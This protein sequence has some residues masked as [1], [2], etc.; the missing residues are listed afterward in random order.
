MNLKTV[1]PF[2]YTFPAANPKFTYHN[3]RTTLPRTF[4]YDQTL[5]L[6]RFHL[7]VYRK[8]S[9]AFLPLPDLPVTECLTAEQRRLSLLILI[10]LLHVRSRFRLMFT[11]R[12]SPVI[13]PTAFYKKEKDGDIYRKKKRPISPLLPRPLSFQS[14]PLDLNDQFFVIHQRVSIRFF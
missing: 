7:P 11:G 1:N 6:Q 2:V 12:F 14:S 4:D 10:K 3:G 8:I 9:I 5:N 13:S